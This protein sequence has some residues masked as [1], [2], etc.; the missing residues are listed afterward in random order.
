M[1]SPTD[2]SGEGGTGE[3]TRVELEGVARD[4]KG[5]AVLVADDGRVVYLEALPSWPEAVEGT[6]VRASGILAR[7]KYIPSPAVA[8][9]GAISQGA[10]GLQDVLRQAEWE[11]AG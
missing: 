10:E 3:G 4:A 1:R 11:P 8:D 2:G 6:R 7:M 5:G 9:D